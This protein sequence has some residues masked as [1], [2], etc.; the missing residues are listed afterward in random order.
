MENRN[1]AE[2]VA[3]GFLERAFKM[4]KQKLSLFE[5]RS[6][7]P[8]QTRRQ[9]LRMGSALL[10]LPWLESLA[11]ARET[12]PPRRMVSICTGF[13]LYAPSFFPVTAGREYEPSEYLKILQ[14]LRNDYTVFSGISHPDIGGDH[15]SEACFLTSARRPT[16]S[17]FRNTVSL[18]T[19][20]AK[21]VGNATRFPLLSLAT[22][23]GGSA[24]T[25]TNGGASV[26]PLHKPS[27]VFRRLFL[28]GT[29]N[30][31]EQEM[32]RLRRGQSI[33]DR[34]GDR[35]ES[36]KTSLSQRDWQQLTDYSEAVRE[37]ERQLQ[38]DE[39]WVA[40]PK[41]TI[42]VDPPK[43]VPDMSD[44]IGR[45]RAMFNLAKLA[46]QTDSTRVITIFIRGMDLRPPIDGVAEDHHGLTHHG[47][48]P[49]KIEQLRIIERLEI[50]ALRD[51]LVSLKSANEGAVTLLDQTQVL[52][53]SN[54]GDASYH[55]TSNLP[56]LLAGGGY[57]HGQH[58][59]GDPKNNTPLGKLYVNMLQRFGVETDKFG[60]GSGTIDGLV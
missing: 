32:K 24:L 38:A 15:A 14:E 18:D 29:A 59:A 6:R 54:L 21:H 30:D 46:L 11:G 39:S 55:G 37:M 1:F 35:F 13:G 53:G 8:S 23:E 3:A 42:D 45:A 51:F 47:R 28:A 44:T 7:M 19:V 26:S 49:T 10:V 57:R 50:E 34:M 33:L 31:V 17:N 58:I 27:D 52:F 22:I 36:L 20:A 43:D 4:L 56:I 2:S 60:S 9:F 41:P 5:T 48:N 12:A 16:S 40:R 25:Y